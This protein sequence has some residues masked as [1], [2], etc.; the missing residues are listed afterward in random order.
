GYLRLSDSNY[1]WGQGLPDLRAWQRRAGV[2]ELDVWYW[3]THPAAVDPSW[4]VR[5]LHPAP[6]DDID[7]ALAGRY[8]AASTTLVYG[9]VLSAPIEPHDP[10]ASAKAAVR[11]IRARLRART[12][13]ARTTTFLIYD[14][15]GF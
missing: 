11:E 12:P 7:R 4:R 1:D 15:T 6:A 3:G 2:N 13:V 9:S 10:D 5:S 14:F 8:L